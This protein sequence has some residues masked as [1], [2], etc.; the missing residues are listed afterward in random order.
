LAAALHRPAVLKVPRAALGL[1]LG[2]EMADEMILA[3]QRV[4]PTRLQGS[5]YRYTDPDIAKALA[6]ILRPT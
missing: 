2:R 5:G 6:R 3:G 4:L 1:V